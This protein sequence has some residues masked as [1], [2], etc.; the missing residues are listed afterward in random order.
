MA[1]YRV[2]KQP[3]N[4]ASPFP[5]AV[6]TQ[7]PTALKPETSERD[8]KRN[9]RPPAPTIDL[10]LPGRL[11]TEE[12][13]SVLKIGKSSFWDGIKTGRYPEPDYHEGRVPFW[14]H[15][16]ILHVIENGCGGAK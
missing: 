15:A 16:T 4:I 6:D 3:F 8:A 13:L 14:K 5:P 10:T 2:H 9:A 11:R 12:V 7:A 1:V